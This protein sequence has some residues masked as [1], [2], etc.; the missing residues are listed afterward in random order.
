MA[1]ETIKIEISK[2]EALMKQFD[3]NIDDVKDSLTNVKTYL[4]KIDGTNDIWRG[5][6]AR[7]YKESFGECSSDFEETKTKLTDYCTGL[8][9]TLENYKSAI[10][11]NKKQVEEIEDTLYMG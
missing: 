7:D 5:E 11:K 6:V 9:N 3:N 2:F 4:G 1:G 8:K 10:S